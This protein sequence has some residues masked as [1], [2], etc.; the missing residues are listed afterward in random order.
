MG[1]LGA[2]FSM[3]RVGRTARARDRRAAHYAVRR[4]EMM[5]TVRLTGTTNIP[6]QPK[7]DRSRLAAARK[8]GVTDTKG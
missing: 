7:G 5:W 6:G 8:H 3:D 4:R 1:L 2:V